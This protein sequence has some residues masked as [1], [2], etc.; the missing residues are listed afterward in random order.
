MHKIQN[1]RKRKYKR[2]L[3]N[4]LVRHTTVGQ[5]KKELK[6]HNCPH[7]IVGIFYFA[8]KIAIVIAQADDH[9]DQDALLL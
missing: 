7:F 2:T 6:E 8:Q 4:W 5:L 9:D 1:K 3:Q